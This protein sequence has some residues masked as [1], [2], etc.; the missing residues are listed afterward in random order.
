MLTLL[1]ITAIYE[2]MNYS[3]ELQSNLSLVME[4]QMNAMMEDEE[5]II[6]DKEMFLAEFV[7]NLVVAL[8]GEYGLTVEILQLDTEKGIFAVRVIAD[9]L[10]LNGKSGQTTCERI[11]IFNQ[12]Q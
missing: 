10:Y 7:E 8:D 1:I 3:M 12:L 4:E 5:H 9:F 6:K 2:R 11:V